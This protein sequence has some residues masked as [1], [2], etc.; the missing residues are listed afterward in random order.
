MDDL[1][2][3]S[4]QQLEQRADNA[5]ARGYKHTGDMYRQWAAV[6]P[7]YPRIQ[8]QEIGF[9]PAKMGADVKVGD[10]LV[11]NYGYKSPVIAVLKE[12][13]AFTTFQIEEEGKLYERRIKKDRLVGCIETSV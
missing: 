11:W 7:D 6:A 12:T 10:V 4:R 2:G 1:R 9:V 13:A 5:D 3:L 8:L